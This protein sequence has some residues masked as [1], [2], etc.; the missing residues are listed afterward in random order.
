MLHKIFISILTI[1]V[2]LIHES[3]A[4]PEL[5]KKL[6]RQDYIEH[7]ANLAIQEMNEFSIPASIIL[8]QACLE[9]SDGNSTLAKMSNNH[10]GIKCKSS[11][12]GETVFYDD[13]QKNECFRKYKSP[14]ESFRDHSRFLNE[15]ARYQFLF[16]F[17]ITDYRKWAY[18]L[19]KAGYATDPQYPDRLI[20]I[21][22]DFHLNE[23][24]RYFKRG[25]NF[26]GIKRRGFTL[27]SSSVRKSG[28]GV[29]EITIDPY[30]TRNVQERNGSK[31]FIANE[32][33]TYEQI[34]GEFSMK[35]WEIF[36]YNDVEKGSRPETNSIV[37]IKS[38][39]GKAPRGNDYHVAKEGESLWSIAQWYGV[40]LNAL[41]RINRMKKGDE[42]LSGQRISLRKRIKR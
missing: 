25:I 19:K 39:R 18:G 30:V 1:T 26:A 9:S 7:F 24:D 34:A 2:L 32:G 40:R 11:W 14:D 16:D 23:L 5:N 37:Y 28:K 27:G 15:S 3:K 4:S 36:K 8:A 12:T 21:I 22:E 20:K 29:G 6:S 13:D 31:A 38:K 35:E 41:Y 10:F 42:P 17:D 33:D